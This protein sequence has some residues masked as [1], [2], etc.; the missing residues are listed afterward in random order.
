MIIAAIPLNNYTVQRRIDKVASNVEARFYSK[1]RN[2][3]FSLQF[4]ES[5]LPSNDSLLAYVKYAVN[6][7]VRQGIL[8]AHL[9]E[10]DIKGKICFQNGQRVFISTILTF[11]IYYHVPQI[12]RLT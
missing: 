4:D 5:T 3:K 1:M 2:C 6:G 7:L 9:M 10:T 11:K 12:A 8:L